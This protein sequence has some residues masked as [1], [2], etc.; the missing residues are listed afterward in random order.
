MSGGGIAGGGIRPPRVSSPALNRPASG[1]AAVGPDTSGGVRDPGSMMSIPHPGGADQGAGGPPERVF[2]WPR[3]ADRVGQR[4]GK[5][6]RGG[7]PPQEESAGATFLRTWPG[8]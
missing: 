6:A 8:F 7:R 5:V 1:F 3:I 2:V 4:Y